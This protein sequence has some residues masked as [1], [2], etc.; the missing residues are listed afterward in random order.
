VGGSSGFSKHSVHFFAW[1]TQRSPAMGGEE[2]GVAVE[3]ELEP[4]SEAVG[5]AGVVKAVGPVIQVELAKERLEFEAYKH[6]E[7]KIDFLSG[8]SGLPRQPGLQSYNA[9]F[10]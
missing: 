4:F 3:S 7:N 9:F 8:L 1:L 5:A 10:S 2:K 6:Q